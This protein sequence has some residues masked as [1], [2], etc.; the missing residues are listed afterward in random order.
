MAAAERDENTI[1]AL[2]AHLEEQRD[3]LQGLTELSEGDEANVDVLAV[4]LYPAMQYSE[5]IR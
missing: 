4:C 2:E 3:T 1:A 5:L